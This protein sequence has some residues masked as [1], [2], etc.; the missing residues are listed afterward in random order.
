MIESRI[1]WVNF[2]LDLGSVS[3]PLLMAREGWYLF[4]FAR[5]LGWGFLSPL[6]SRVV[7]KLMLDL[8]LH[9]SVIN[10]NGERSTPWTDSITSLSGEPPLPSLTYH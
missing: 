6:R 3:A 1:Q 5:P 10:R 4:C 8:V 7:F 2:T 9:Q